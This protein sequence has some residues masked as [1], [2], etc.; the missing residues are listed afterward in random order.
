MMKTERKSDRQ[1]EHERSLLF[2]ENTEL[3]DFTNLKYH[4]AID[5]VNSKYDFS[6][7]DIDNQVEILLVKGQTTNSGNN[8]SPITVKKILNFKNDEPTIVVRYHLKN[9]LQSKINLHFGTEIGFGAYTFPINESQAS[10]NQ[11]NKID[12]HLNSE[13][14]KI[15]SFIFHSYRSLYRCD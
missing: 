7:N 12:L 13:I 9:E 3:E 11:Q 8:D 10:C 6:I 1:I 4:E 14:N 15:N 2:A 5:F